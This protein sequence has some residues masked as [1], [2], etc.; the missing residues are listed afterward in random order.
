[1]SVEYDIG[2]LDRLIMGRW[3]APA[4]E[5]SAYITPEGY[6]K[7]EQENTTLWTKRNVVTKAVT[8]A[9][10]EGDRSENAEYI[11]RKK[12]LREIDSRIAYLQRRMPKLTVVRQTEDITKVFFGAWITIKDFSGKERRYRIVGADEFDI[13]EHYIT[14]DSPLAK[15]MMGKMINDKIV[16]E[17]QGVTQ[18]LIIINIEY[19]I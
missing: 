13:N 9:A 14:V 15:S 16:F 8:A 10:A 19:I 11:Y 2:L 4:S 6:R 3:R 17:R 7:L 12:Q 5:S 1:L 18:A